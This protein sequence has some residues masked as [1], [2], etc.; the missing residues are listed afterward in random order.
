M[1]A[2]NLA[3]LAHDARTLDD[4][5]FAKRHGSFFFVSLGMQ[6]QMTRVP[7]VTQ[8]YERPQQKPETTAR[9][10]IEALTAA[11]KPFVGSS[12]SLLRELVIIPARRLQT[13]QFPFVSIGRLEGNDIALGDPTISKFHAYL[14]ADDDGAF[15]LLQDG[16]SQNGT[17]VDG[18]RVAQRH[19]GPPTML[20]SRQNVRFG[21][22]ALSFLDAASVMRLAQNVGEPVAAAFA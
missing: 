15:V 19:A 22:I 11:S 13:S 14:K 7:G 8:R 2:T 6:M 1:N 10:H 5:V 17:Y 18:H 12:T 4:K 16:R 9:T 21:S 3:T 20:V